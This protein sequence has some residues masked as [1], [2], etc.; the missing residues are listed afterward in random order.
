MA[1]FRGQAVPPGTSAQSLDHLR[2]FLADLIA[3]E[4]PDHRRWGAFL[5]EA[6]CEELAQ[7]GQALARDQRHR[8]E[9]LDRLGQF[10]QS[11]DWNRRDSVARILGALGDRRAIPILHELLSD[12]EGLVRYAALKGLWALGAIRTQDQV[13][14]LLTDPSPIVQETAASFQ[15]AL[16]AQSPTVEPRDRSRT[17]GLSQEVRG[18]SSCLK[19]LSDSTRLEILLILSEGEQ[20]TPALGAQ[21]NQSQPAVSHHLALLR[22]GGF[23]IPD[24]QG[25]TTS[26]RLTET[27][28]RWADLVESL[29]GIARQQEG[30]QDRVIPRATRESKSDSG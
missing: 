17:T 24:H 11:P 12:P 21:L 29:A 28:R 6:G 8:T 25:R 27:G 5:D 19:L 30:A 2:R 13:K 16:S 9:V 10:A 15:S 14:E 22:H 3:A 18:L 4:L 26:Y 1:L 7:V 23:V 20:P